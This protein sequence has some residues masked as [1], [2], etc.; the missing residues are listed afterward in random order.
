MKN[1]I[2][3]ISLIRISIWQIQCNESELG[4]FDPNF[5]RYDCR[6]NPDSQKR[7]IA[8]MLRFYDESMRNSGADDYFGLV[9]PKFC[10]KASITGRDFLSWI[11][12]SPGHDVYF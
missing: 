9:S 6:D 7:E 11:E 3:E 5:L 10:D 2:A 8:H 4:Y 12:A 1:K